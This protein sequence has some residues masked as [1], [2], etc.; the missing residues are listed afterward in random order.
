MNVKDLVRQRLS[1][2][3][4]N[5]GMHKAWATW[6]MDVKEIRKMRIAGAKVIFR[7]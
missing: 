3:M 2:R 4:R 6:D 7:W 5:L 1:L